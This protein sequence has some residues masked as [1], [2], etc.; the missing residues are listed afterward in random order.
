MGL[1]PPWSVRSLNA[2]VAESSPRL[3]STGTRCA[4][5]WPTSLVRSA[6]R[7]DT[8][9]AISDT[10]H[11]SRRG[12]LGLVNY[13]ELRAGCAPDRLRGWPGQGRSY[14]TCGGRQRPGSIAPWW[15]R[16]KIFTA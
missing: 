3:G 14:V 16:A 12:L 9:G 6:V 5:R 4:R 10:P 7:V 8:D 15:P 11:A 13:A 1:E 2:G